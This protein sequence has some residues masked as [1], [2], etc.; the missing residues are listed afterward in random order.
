MPKTKMNNGARAT[1]GVAY[2]AETHGSTKSL[3]ASL[4]AMATPSRMPNTAATAK[5]T[6]NSL[7]LTRMCRPNSPVAA[8]CRNLTQMSEIGA[9]ISGH[10]PLRPAISQRRPTISSDSNPRTV[11]ACARYQRRRRGSRRWRSS[12][13]PRAMLAIYACPQRC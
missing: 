10:R 13:R 5:P 8:S 2:T 4:L 12:S 3:M 6:K 11:D 7:R 1:V 9:R